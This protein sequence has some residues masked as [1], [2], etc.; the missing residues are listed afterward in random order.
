[1]G[2]GVGSLFGRGS[3]RRVDI[4]IGVGRGL[5]DCHAVMMGYMG[6]MVFFYRACFPVCSMKGCSRVCM[7]CQLGS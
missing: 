1:M 7:Q 4:A 3:G 5:G 6:F 2:I